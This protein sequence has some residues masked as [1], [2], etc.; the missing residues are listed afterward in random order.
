MSAVR[1]GLLLAMFDSVST[2][3]CAAVGVKFV[4]T[5]AKRSKDVERKQLINNNMISFDWR[6]LLKSNFRLSLRG[7]IDE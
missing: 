5:D 3:V 4:L 1:A 2:R 7:N 6:A